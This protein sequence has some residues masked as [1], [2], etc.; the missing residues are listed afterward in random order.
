[1]IRD[2]D[3]RQQRMLALAILILVAVV[4]IS[5]TVLPVWS[6]NRNYNHRI[7]TLEGRLEQLQRAAAIGANLEPRYQQL[8]Q[9]LASDQHYLK[10]TSEALATAELQQL[11]KD[12]AQAKKVEVLSM[13]NLPASKQDDDRRAALKVRTRGDL[14]NIIQM[15]HALET[16]S[17][18]L[19]LDKVS[20]RNVMSRRKTIPDNLPLDAD[21][22]IFGYL[23]PES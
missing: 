12:I 8:K 14:E 10:S 1:V 3:E 22:E 5:I 4:I 15:F 16:G 17:P 21:F 23:A 13:Q 2:L 11:V 7:A 20:I 6:A 19:F 18:F 9:L